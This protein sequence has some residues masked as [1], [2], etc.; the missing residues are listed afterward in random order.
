MTASQSALAHEYPFLKALVRFV[1]DIIVGC[2]DGL[3]MWNRYEALSRLS[4][5][6]LASRG[7]TRA[8]ITRLVVH[9]E[10]RRQCLDSYIVQQF[11]RANCDA[12]AP[13]ISSHSADA[14]Q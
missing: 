7:L 6:E 14:D 12:Q 3:E 2:R 4:N 1:E 5:W 13:R 10:R 9:G 8:S 11:E